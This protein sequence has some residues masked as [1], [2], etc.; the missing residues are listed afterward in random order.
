[1]RIHLLTPADNEYIFISVTATNTKTGEAKMTMTETINILKSLGFVWEP[2]TIGTKFDNGVWN[3][4]VFLK[5]DDG[6][7]KPCYGFLKFDTAAET[8][9][10]KVALQSAA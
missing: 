1:M 10:A 5:N 7:R 8:V 6:S 3:V 2:N 9:A 4:N